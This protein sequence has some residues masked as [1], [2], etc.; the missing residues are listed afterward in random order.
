MRALIVTNKIGPG[1]TTMCSNYLHIDIVFTFSYRDEL[2]GDSIIILA[3][4]LFVG[5]T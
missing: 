4:L 1:K 2:I 5:V 3:N